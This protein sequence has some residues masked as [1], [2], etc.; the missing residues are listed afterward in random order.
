MWF[1]LL[2]DRPERSLKLHLFLPSLLA[3]A[4]VILGGP[5]PA[6][7]AGRGGGGGGRA[8]WNRRPHRSHHLLRCAGSCKSSAGRHHRDH[9]RAST[10]LLSA[11]LFLLLPCENPPSWRPHLRNGEPSQVH[12]SA[13][14]HPP[15]PVAIPPQLTQP[16]LTS[17]PARAQNQG[18]LFPGNDSGT[19]DQASANKMQC[20]HHTG[21][22]GL[23]PT[24]VAILG[25][26]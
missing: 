2:H 25:N 11:G 20:P 14:P 22:T 24:R 18:L 19:G 4:A 8:S 1:H 17:N 9:S 23:H 10:S 16:T 13:L 21:E 7:A 26:F 5:L 3:F 6:P 15:A 12:G